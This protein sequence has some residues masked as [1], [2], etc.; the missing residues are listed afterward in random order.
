MYNSFDVFDTLIGRLCY[1][2]TNIFDIIEKISLI[3]NFKENRIKFE[4]ETQD[5]N[6]TYIELEKCYGFNMQHIKQKELELEYELCFPIINN[7]NNV[8]QNDILI[9][10][11]YL[12]ED[13]ILKLLNKFKNIQN[14]IYVSYGGKK[15]NTIWKNKMLV[16]Q[17]NCHYGDNY[18]SD[19]INPSSNGINACHI[20]NV[21]LTGI[22]IQMSKINQ[23]I[24][25]IMRAV[26]LSLNDNYI[27]TN[28]FINYILPFSILVCL[29]IKKLKNENN[30][31]KIIFLARD[32]YWFKEMYNILYPNDDT[33]YLYFSRLLVKNNSSNIKNQINNIKGKKLIFDLQG[34]GRTFNSLELQNCFYFMCF[35]SHDTNL[36]NYMYRHTSQVV[37]IKGIIER[38]F[39]APHGSCNYYNNNEIQLLDPEHDILLFKPY[40][41][42]YKIFKKYWSIISKYYNIDINFHELENVINNFHNNID[43]QIELVNFINPILSHVENH[44]DTYIP[45][46]MPFFSQI[47]QDKYYIEN[48]IKY[49]PNGTFIEIGGYD[50]ITG[51]NTYFLE[52]Y[53]NWDGIIVECNPYLIDKCKQN[54][55]CIICDKAIYKNDNE[56]VTFKIPMGSE[57]PGGKAQLGGIKNE[58]KKESIVTFHNSYVNSIDISVNTININTLLQKHQIYEIDYLS[59]DVE[60]SELTILKTWNFNKHKVKFITVEHGNVVSYQKLIF[61]FLTDS[62]FKLHRNNKWDDEYVYLHN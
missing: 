53:L 22:E 32:G 57:I 60:G 9:S 41:E 55:N 11:M 62:G 35:L 7:L 17:I 52:K 5:F 23:H 46:K 10:D 6:R 12:S 27:L 44:T 14:K 51:S 54:R 49:K 16:S 42:G 36:K 8:K 43:Y 31:D 25:Y 3:K 30:I 15:N 28:T 2:G 26:R 48:I 58:L 20:N 56:V 33:E 45:K 47:E 19:Y 13:Q 37:N 34:S 61:D 18:I 59:I 21:T 39:N 40:F 50:G 29:K 1:N 4:S 38:I 24:G